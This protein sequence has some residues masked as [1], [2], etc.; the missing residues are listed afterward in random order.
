M[1]TKYG[2]EGPSNFQSRANFTA[3]CADAPVAAKPATAAASNALLRMRFMVVAPQIEPGS[4]PVAR[5][6]ATA[7]PAVNASKA[8]KPGNSCVQFGQQQ[9]VLPNRR[10]GPKSG[11][12]CAQ[13]KLRTTHV[14]KPRG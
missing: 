3:V 11:F 12:R 8:C 7:M 9:R 4:R 2:A 10:P 5:M 6:L 1:A 13:L 14:Q